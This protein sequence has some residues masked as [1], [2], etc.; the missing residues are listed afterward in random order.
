MSSLPDVNSYHREILRFLFHDRLNVPEDKREDHA[1]AAVN[2]AMESVPFLNGSL[3]AEHTDDDQ[4]DISASEYWSA[5]EEEPGLFTIFSRYHWTMDEHRPGESEQTLDPELLS[6]LFE[7]LITPTEEGTEP[8][9]RQP[10]GTYYTPAD[11]PTK[12]LRTLWPPP[13]GNMFRPM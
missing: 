10:Q 5:D 8:P 4:L 2:E 12:W 3:F 6:N 1:N 9:L 13:C 7:R 11:V